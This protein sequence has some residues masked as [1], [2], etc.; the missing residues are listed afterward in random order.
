MGDDYGGGVNSSDFGSEMSTFSDDEDDDND[1]DEGVGDD[2]N[3]WAYAIG[4]PAPPLLAALPNLR[5]CR[6]QFVRLPRDCDKRDSFEACCLATPMLLITPADLIALRAPRLE[7]LAI[8]LVDPND[9]NG[10]VCYCCGEE[11]G[12][13]AEH[14]GAAAAAIAAGCSGLPALQSLELHVGCYCVEEIGNPAYD[15]SGLAPGSLPALRRLAVL[16]RCFNCCAAKLPLDTLARAAPALERLVVGPCCAGPLDALFC[17]AGDGCAHTLRWLTVLPPP[18]YDAAAPA[19]LEAELHWGLRARAVVCLR[20]RHPVPPINVTLLANAGAELPVARAHAHGAAI[21]RR[22][23]SG[24]DG[25]YIGHFSHTSLRCGTLP[26]NAR[27]DPFGV[28]AYER[29]HA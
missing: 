2:G 16:P 20:T 14:A 9:G 10:L 28:A 23:F 17:S 1:D 8:G 11:N 22:V 19:R 4:I 15:L 3:A 13:A 21:A 27:E 24:D 25:S 12:L 18:F 26:G 6:M 5:H 7:S 29:A